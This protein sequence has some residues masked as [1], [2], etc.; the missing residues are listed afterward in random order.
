[1]TTQRL[2]RSAQN[3]KGS[4]VRELRPRTPAVPPSVTLDRPDTGYIAALA[5]LVSVGMI[6]VYSTTAIDGMSA[7]LKM[8]IWL[9]VSIPMMAAGIFLPL[10]FWRKLAPAFLVLC[11][12]A[13]ASLLL[14]SKNPLA[15]EVNGAYR[16][17]G[18]EGVLGVQPSEYAKLAYILFAAKFLEKRGQRMKGKDWLGFVLMLGLMAGM[19]YKEPDLGTAMVIAGTA[20]CMLVAAGAR[21]GTL[22]KGML[23]LVVVVGTL[24]WN[25]QHQRERLLAWWNPWSVEYRQEGG[26]QVLQ[27]WSAMSRGGLWGRGLGQSTHKLKDRLPEAETDFI[28]AIV[29]EEMGLFRAAGVL[30]L[31]GLL[32]WRGYSIAARAPDRY[33]GLVT[34]GITSWIAVQAC[35]NV[36]VVTGTVPNTGVPLPFI[37]SGGSSLTALLTAAGIV[38]GISRQRAAREGKPDRAS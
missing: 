29:A 37:S 28:F 26:Y 23:V 12:I 13:L 9:L 32:A 16:W 2:G 34:V 33:A 11:L 30:L 15:F 7:V 20:L 10:G 5:A 1:L 31:F 36:A 35:L 14:K 24:A 6:M 21:W 19:I 27:S 17:L 4:N 3:R 25:T 22:L 18:K 8:G 38:I